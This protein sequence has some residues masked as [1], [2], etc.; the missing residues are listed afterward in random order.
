MGK[1]PLGTRIAE[2]MGAMRFSWTSKSLLDKK[3]Q[4]GIIF[5][6]YTPDRYL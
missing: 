3:A 5:E 4:D 2:A 1:K 6:H